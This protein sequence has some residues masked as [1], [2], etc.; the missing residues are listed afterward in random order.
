MKYNAKE[1]QAAE[2]KQS[3]A[4]AEG[5]G[6]SDSDDDDDEKYNN[7]KQ[8]ELL[9]KVYMKDSTT[10]ERTMRNTQRAESSFISELKIMIKP[11]EESV[12]QAQAEPEK[13]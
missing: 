10:I 3:A 7:L 11:K 12:G 9:S 1:R 8:H 4:K 13:R 2:A 6:A 5:H